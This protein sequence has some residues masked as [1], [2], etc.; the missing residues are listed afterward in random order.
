[1]KKHILIF[2]AVIIFSVNLFAQST[3]GTNIP[4]DRLPLVS[5]NPR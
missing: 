4:D 5:S 3:I 1:M 2:I